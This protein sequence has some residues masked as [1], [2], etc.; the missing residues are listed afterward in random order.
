MENVVVV[1]GAGHIGLAI[2]RRVGVGK[3][4]VLADRSE[5]NANAA[6]EVMAN[7]G[8]QVSVATVDVSSRET[9]H[10]LVGQVTGIGDCGTDPCGW[11]LTQPGVTGD[12]PSCGSTAPR[13]CSSSSGM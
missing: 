13:S 12:D 5:A 10:A 11:R 1:V 4:V 2:A 7:A 3:H 9:V 8:Y 6:A